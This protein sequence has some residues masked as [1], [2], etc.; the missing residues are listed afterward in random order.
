MER[1]I[2]GVAHVT[3]A[4]AAGQ[5]ETTQLRVLMLLKEKA[6]TG[7][8]LDGEW[9]VTSE[10]LACCRVHGQDRRVASGC[11]TSCSS[12]GCGCKE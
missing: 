1:M 5:L 3:A 10:S 6:L 12:G 11:A 9:F 4:A 2:E 8:M 7:T